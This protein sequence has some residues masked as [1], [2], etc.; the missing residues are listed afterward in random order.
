VEVSIIVPDTFLTV[1]EYNEAHVGIK[2]V[3]HGSAGE[4]HVKYSTDKFKTEFDAGT[5]TIGSGATKVIEI[6][7]NLKRGSYFFTARVTKDGKTYEAAARMAVGE[8]YQPHFM[9]D[10]TVLGACLQVPITNVTS[11]TRAQSKQNGENAI[12]LLEYTGLLH[13]RFGTGT[14]AEFNIVGGFGAPLGN[15]TESNTIYYYIKKL[16][17]K[18]LG[19]IPVSVG[20]DNSPSTNTRELLQYAM[21]YVRDKV[22]LKFGTPTGIYWELGNEPDLEKYFAGRDLTAIYYTQLMRYHFLNLREADDNLN[23]VGGVV[24]GGNNA[25]NT[26]RYMLA[27]GGYKYM[28]GYSYHPYIKAFKVDDRYDSFC[29]PYEKVADGYGGWL[30]RAISEMGW[31]SQLESGGSVMSYEEAAV[32]YVKAFLKAY[33]H[34]LEFYTHYSL[35]NNL[36]IQTQNDTS[37]AT[38]GTIAL[39]FL[40]KNLNSAVYAGQLELTE[41]I[42]CQMFYSLGEPLLVVWMPGDEPFEYKFNTPVDVYDIYGN[43]EYTSDTVVMDEQVK[44]IRGV[45]KDYIYRAACEEKDR[46]FEDISETYNGKF[47][48]SIFNEAKAVTP[49]DIAKDSFGAVKAMYDVGDKLIEQYANGQTTMEVKE[50]SEALYRLHLAGR[51]MIVA[52]AMDCTVNNGVS[53]KYVEVSRKMD[54]LRGDKYNLILYSDKI[55]KF[56]QRLYNKAMDLNGREDHPLKAGAVS[57][58]S[59]MS[60]RLA[61]WA[62]KLLPFQE[63]DDT[64]GI[65]SFNWPVEATMY[66]TM[67]YTETLMTVDNFRSVPVEGDLIVY[68][69]AGEEV[70][71]RTHVKIE[72]YGQVQHTIKIYN[73]KSREENEIY[74]IKLVTSEGRVMMEKW[75]SVKRVFGVTTELDAAHDTFDNLEYISVKVA[76]NTPDVTQSGTIKITS[77][78]DG[79]ELKEYEKTYTVQGSETIHVKFPIEHKVQKAF[80]MYNFGIQIF[81]EDGEILTDRK[82]PLNFPF[83][84]YTNKELTIEDFISSNADMS[85]WYN[86]YPVYATRGSLTEGNL[87]PKDPDDKQQWL[88]SSNAAVIFYKFDKNYL[89]IMANQY[90]DM[91][92]VTTF[93]EGLWN[94]DSI[95]TVFDT[96]ANGGKINVEDDYAFTIGHSREGFQ[97]VPTF[98]KETTGVDYDRCMYVLRDDGL[99]QTRYF[100]KLPWTAFNNMLTGRVGTR[101]RTNIMFNDS[102]A[103]PGRGNYIEVQ[104]KLGSGGNSRE[105]GLWWDYVMVDEEFPAV[106]INNTILD[107]K[108]INPIIPPAR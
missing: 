33:S 72:P 66:S 81:D 10:Y 71:E 102:D 88:N 84:M 91:V 65:V 25:V 90:D 39:T 98:G 23:F 56:A 57:S 8:K 55:M 64:A 80:N 6:R 31:D 63:V 61:T 5:Y 16:R 36:G 14:R 82:V 27:Q 99:F 7:E 59:Y 94:S 15:Y 93:G 28:D 22:R 69:G 21:D 89:Y 37:I 51:K 34:D 32:E 70:G 40:T 62:E 83:V 76:N 54:E 75:F 3:N 9:D 46:A 42:Q 44:Y 49:E 38:N 26:L 58:N 101:F 24:S 103:T 104:D 68:N 106:D 107:L 50:V 60:E 87:F 29:A 18:C 45:E 1:Q 35:I 67:E 78:P 73:S 92:T 43:L 100:I 105:P 12:R 30:F 74:T 2:I 97:T 85:S 48:P 95:Q 47:D 19:G 17:G 96:L 86:A 52:Y 41:G 4:F 79:W 53:G 108:L 77:V 11:R 20:G 13:N